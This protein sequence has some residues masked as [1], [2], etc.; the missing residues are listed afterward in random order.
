MGRAARI[1]KGLAGLAGLAIVVVGVPAGPALPVRASRSVCLG[2]GLHDGLSPLTDSALLRGVGAVLGDLGFVR[3]RPG[4]RGRRPG[5]L[6]RR[7]GTGADPRTARSGQH[8]PRQRH[9]AVTS[10]GPCCKRAGLRE[11][12]G[13]DDGRSCASDGDRPVNSARRR[14]SPC[15]PPVRPT[16]WSATSWSATTRPGA[17]PSVTSVT[18]PAGTSSSTSTDVLLGARRRR[19]KHRERAVGRRHPSSIRAMSSSCPETLVPANRARNGSRDPARTW[20]RRCLTASTWSMP[21]PC[22]LPRRWSTRPPPPRTRAAHRHQHVPGVPMPLT[23]PGVHPRPVRRRLVRRHPW[24]RLPRRRRR[25]P[26][27]SNPLV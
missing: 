23:L 22:H 25:P 5:R 21:A 7:E 9:V 19:Q 12:A 13:Q 18:A 24:R 2:R 27:L 3:G 11:D 16:G 8:A 26:R 15:R 20:D 6:T 10:T 1:A 14:P 4:D 17:S